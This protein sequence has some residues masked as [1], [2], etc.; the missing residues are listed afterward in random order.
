M[1]T[2]EV[3]TRPDP[4]PVPILPYYRVIHVDE[5]DG[6]RAIARIES[7]MRAGEVTPRSYRAKKRN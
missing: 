2:R 1:A 6:L 4:A 7:L 5:R 3:E